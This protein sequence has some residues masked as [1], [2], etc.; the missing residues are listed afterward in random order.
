V[1][2]Q[3]FGS[4]K[5]ARKEV[6]LFVLF[7]VLSLLEKVPGIMKAQESLSFTDGEERKRGI[8]RPTL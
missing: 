5:K 7:P 2:V 4:G 1:T 8:Q 3:K 6:F